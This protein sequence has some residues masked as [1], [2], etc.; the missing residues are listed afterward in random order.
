MMVALARFSSLLELDHAAASF[1]WYPSDKQR[2][3]IRQPDDFDISIAIDAAREQIMSLASRI[4]PIALTGVLEPVINLHLITEPC[5]SAAFR[6]VAVPQQLDLNTIADHRRF[7]HELALRAGEY[8]LDLELGHGEACARWS[9]FD[10][11]PM[12]CIRS[13]FVSY[14]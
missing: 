11:L 2:A 12:P 9:C 7:E 4:G 5:W 13:G 6:A 8:E 1:V 10:T 14:I 3:S